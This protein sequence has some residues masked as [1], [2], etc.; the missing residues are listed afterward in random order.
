MSKFRTVI[1]LDLD[2]IIAMLPANAHVHSKT[3][4]E[5]K[6]TG[7]E[8]IFDDPAAK[9]GFTFPVEKSIFDLQKEYGDRREAARAALF[10]KAQ[11]NAEAEAEVKRLAA[12][13]AAQIAKEEGAVVD[14]VAGTGTLEAPTAEERP[15]T[16]EEIQAAQDL[17][18]T[19]AEA[20]P[21]DKPKRRR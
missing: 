16:P 1:P 10:E 14:P 17:V 8:I 4:I 6:E 2:S 13:A 5:G 11:R 19:P 7:L 21:V 9:T 12:E 15:A 20:K 3:F 18:A